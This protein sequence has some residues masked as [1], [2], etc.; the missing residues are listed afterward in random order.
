MKYGTSD[1]N[2]FDHGLLVFDPNPVDI[3]DGLSQAL[4]N[5]LF[6]ELNKTNLHDLIFTGEFS[7]N[8]TEKEKNVFGEY[9]I[10][11]FTELAALRAFGRLSKVENMVLPD[12]RVW[13]ITQSG[14][15][16]GEVNDKGL[17]HG[18]GVFIGDQHSVFRASFRDGKAD[19]YMHRIDGRYVHIG[20]IREN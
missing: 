15:Y 3:N 14:R 6:E 18:E 12:W 17:P 1:D 2:D 16:T 13:Q 4:T 11:V 7:S 10:G 8:F 5:K 20:E 19:G 9:A